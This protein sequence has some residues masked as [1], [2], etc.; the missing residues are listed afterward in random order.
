MAGTIVDNG[1]GT[2]SIVFTYTAET[3]RINDTV[4]DAVEYLYREEDF[5]TLTNQDKVDWLDRWFRD[6]VVKYAT[7]QHVGDGVDA[8]RI[9]ATDEA[10]SRYLPDA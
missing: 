5:D 1:D 6:E 2:H 8:A 3:Q 7:R 9:A 10:G 4:N